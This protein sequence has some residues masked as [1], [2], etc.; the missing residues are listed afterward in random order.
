MALNFTLQTCNECA[1]LA[2]AHTDDAQPR[3]SELEVAFTPVPPPYAT[4]GA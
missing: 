2:L 3:I 1:Q 4:Q